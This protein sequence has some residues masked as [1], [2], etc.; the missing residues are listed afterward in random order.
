MEIH[1]A[2]AG[3]R[4]RGAHR[5]PNHAGNVMEFQVQENAWAKAG[6]FFHS[7]GAFGRE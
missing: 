6:Q 2:Y 7:D 3:Q 4:Y 1:Q 5:A